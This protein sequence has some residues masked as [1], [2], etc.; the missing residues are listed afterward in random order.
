MNNLPNETPNNQSPKKKSIIARWIIGGFFAMFALVNGF[1]YS[2][3]FLLCAAFLMFP[4]PFMASFLQKRNI[5]T[6]FAIILSALL[7]FVGAVTAPPS[8]ETNSNLNNTTQSTVEDSKDK[9]GNFTKPNNSSSN[10]TTKPDNSSSNTTKPDSSSSND[11]K[12]E[13]V[14]VA[15][16]GSKYHSRSTC[17]NMTS[18]RQISL[19]DAKK[20]G[21]TACKKCH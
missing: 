20:Q 16:S 14:W 7:F 17:S 8:E 3:L 9:D 11:E 6:V 19:D 15:S 1:H 21:Y 4:L 18:P 12:I 13:M 10:S 5:K 2:S